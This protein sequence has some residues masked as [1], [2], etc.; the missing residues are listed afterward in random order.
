[1]SKVL[2]PLDFGLPAGTSLELLTAL[3]KIAIAFNRAD[4]QPTMPT[5]ENGWDNFGAPQQ[6]VGYYKDNNGRV[7]LRGA[8][9]DGT[10]GA[11]PAFTLPEGYRPAAWEHFD[12]ESNHAFGSVQIADDGQVQG[13]DGDPTHVSLSGI[14]F[15]AA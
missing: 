12:V 11:V 4:D 8:I 10:I 2:L 14:S 6:D 3:R 9:K 1:M 7:W 13:R 5:F 15:R